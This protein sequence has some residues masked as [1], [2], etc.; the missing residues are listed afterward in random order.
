MHERVDRTE[1][2]WDV[3][4]QSRAVSGVLEA[5]YAV[6]DGKLFNAVPDATA[7]KRE[8]AVV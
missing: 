8:A 1:T 7:P 5:R 3:E 4:K 2:M 6:V